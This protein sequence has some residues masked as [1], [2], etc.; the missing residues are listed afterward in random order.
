MK[1]IGKDEI[2]I[3]D[4]SE[5]IDEKMVNSFGENVKI[6][7]RKPKLNISRYCPFEEINIDEKKNEAK[8]SDLETIREE[9]GPNLLENGQIL[10][11]FE[12]I[13]GSTNRE[14]Y[15]LDR[16]SPNIGLELLKNHIPIKKTTTEMDFNGTSNLQ[17][18]LSVR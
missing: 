3:R 14:N 6:N 13:N 7:L 4:D 5:K 16:K 18:G 8:K 2:E 9:N 15:K 17:R 10:S 12:M 11:E 1:K